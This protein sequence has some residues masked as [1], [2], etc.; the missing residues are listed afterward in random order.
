MQYHGR[1]Y[2]TVTNRAGLAGQ[3]RAGRK[4]RA[5]R[6]RQGRREQDSCTASDSCQLMQRLTAQ[7]ER[8]QQHCKCTLN[9]G[10]RTAVQGMKKK[11][12]RH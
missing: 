12:L 10:T 9:I 6:T 5:G 8:N 3:G 11:R 7:H 4:G 1:L 2:T